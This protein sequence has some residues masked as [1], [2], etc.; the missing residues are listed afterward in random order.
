VGNCLTMS[1]YACI[2]FKGTRRKGTGSALWRIETTSCEVDAEGHL[3]AMLV[4][5]VV[6]TFSAFRSESVPD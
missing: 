6:S 5:E 3:N 1:V 2:P 4:V